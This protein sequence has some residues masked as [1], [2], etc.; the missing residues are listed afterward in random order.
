[1]SVTIFYEPIEQSNAIDVPAPVTFRKKLAKAFGGDEDT[2]LP[3]T[4]NGQDVPILRGMSAT[5]LDDN[6]PYQQIIDL[7][8]KYDQ[9]RVWTEY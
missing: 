5:Q 2:I 8:E 1:M 9:I 4:F 7:I 3:R 6:N